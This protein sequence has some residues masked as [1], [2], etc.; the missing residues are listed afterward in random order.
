MIKYD[1]QAIQAFVCRQWMETLLSITCSWLHM[2][3]NG[4]E[5]DEWC[6]GKHDE[7]TRASVPTRQER[8]RAHRLSETAEQREER[9]RKQKH[10]ARY[11]ANTAEQTHNINEQRHYRLEQEMEQ[12]QEVRLD[13][14]GASRREQLVK[15]TSK[16]GTSDCWYSARG[17]LI[18]DAT[19]WWSPDQPFIS[20]CILRTI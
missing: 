10:G 4:G 11:V 15:A 9:L 12:Q 2:A 1:G 16:R 5:R 17:L 7:L 13:G 20:Q 3:V 18:S 19:N 14:K 8:E 6:E